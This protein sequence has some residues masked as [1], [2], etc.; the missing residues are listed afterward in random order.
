MSEFINTA[1]VIGDDEMC[2][3][4]IQRTVTEYREN[5]IAKIGQYAFSGCTA[6]SVVDVPEVT[7]IE[8]NSLNGCSALEA[9]VLGGDTVVT[10]VNT[11]A[12]TG[13]GIAKGTGRIYVPKAL[14]SQYAGSTNWSTFSAQLLAREDYPEITGG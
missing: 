10:L 6:L 14:L 3:Q 8:A 9:L 1:D 2:D 11:N 13:S 7:S 12:L 4:I 5:R